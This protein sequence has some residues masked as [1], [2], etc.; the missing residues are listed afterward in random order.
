M[1]ISE[2][3]LNKFIGDIEFE[4]AE[5]VPFF[6]VTEDSVLKVT[7][8]EGVETETK[9]IGN[10]YTETLDGITYVK[11][12]SDHRSLGTLTGAEP[13]YRGGL[14]GQ[15]PYS[16]E[17]QAMWAEQFGTAYSA[18]EMMEKR[19]L[20]AMT[21]VGYRDMKVEE[22]VEQQDSTRIEFEIELKGKTLTFNCGTQKKFELDTQIMAIE[23]GQQVKG[24]I[25]DKYFANDATFDLDELKAIK[26]AMFQATVARE[27]PIGAYIKRLMTLPEG[28]E[29]TDVDAMLAAE[30]SA[31]E[32]TYIAGV[33]AEMVGQ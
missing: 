33:I 13:T 20:A 1:K 22:L 14:S 24:A 11:M 25:H 19:R 5:R 10:Y 15:S 23:A 28:F 26:S 29:K 2:A 32:Q 27:F 4:S 18:N 30:L 17:R 3:A 21:P 6:V 16:L 7:D 31:E 8:V 12:D 9:V